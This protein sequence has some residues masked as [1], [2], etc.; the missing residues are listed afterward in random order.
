MLCCRSIWNVSTWPSRKL[1]IELPLLVTPCW[2]V[3]VV[4]NAND[5]VGFGGATAFNWYQRRSMPALKACA[6]VNTTE[7]TA[8]HTAGLV[9]R[10]GARRWPKLLKSREGE[11]RKRIVECGVGWD[12][13][14]P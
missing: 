10:E 7:S 9:L 6:L 5:P 12:T 2:F 13:G 11:E 3:P 14:N 1:A 4:V 8:S